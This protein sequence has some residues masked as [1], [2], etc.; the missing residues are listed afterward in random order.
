MTDKTRRYRSINRRQALAGG[1]GLAGSALAAP[2]LGQG[3]PPPRTPQ[4]QPQPRAQ[5]RQAEP[6]GQAPIMFLHGNGDSGSSWIPT[7]WRF[8]TNNYPRNLLFAPDLPYPAARTVDA[9]PQPFRSSTAEQLDFLVNH[10]R[11]I[12]GETRRRKLVLIGHARGGLTIRNYLKNAGGNEFVSH[13]IL[14]ASPNRGYIISDK[15]MVGSEFNGASPFLR[16]L[17]EGDSDVIPGVS[18]MALRSDKLDKYAQPDGQFIGLA[19]KPTGI[20]FEA[21]ELRGGKNVV[22]PGLDHR[23]VAFHK[24]A[25]A[26]MYEFLLG[27]QPNTLFIAPERQP[28]LSGRV[29][30]FAEG[31]PTNLPVAGATVEIYEIDGRTGERRTAIAMH[32]KVTGADGTWGPFRANFET[33]Y[34]FVIAVS[35][36]PT[37][38]L[39]RSP[40][41][42][43]SDVV[44]LR[45]MQFARGENEAQAV[46]VMTRPRGYFG[47]G[48]DQFLLD[49]KVPAGVNEGVPGTATARAAFD[50]E[51][52]RTVI[53]A[54]NND[55]IP[56]RTWPSRENRIA[57]A[58]FSN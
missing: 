33:F 53:C 24:L 55:I 8:E 15:E 10:V 6:P 23:E 12:L 56:A 1:L 52:R 42:R 46:V 50:A 37:T 14:C 44:H 29:T 20:T 51:P 57:V 58:E 39:Y 25:F 5:Q 19:G 18:M 31:V 22:L 27:R 38:H 40:F 21:P 9:V 2:V 36:N 41:L 54:F 48:R 26:D 3:L 43:S 45:P 4:G 28:V 47:H 17:N 34:E 11:Q 35:G 49:N 16:Q 32:R 30:G 7:L 13:A